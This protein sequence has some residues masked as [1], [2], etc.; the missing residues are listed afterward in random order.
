MSKK[1]YKYQLE[2]TDDI[3]KL[4]IPEGGQ[5]LSVQEQNGGISIWFLVDT[6][7]SDCPREFVI[8]GTGHTVG[9]ESVHH[10]GTV[11]MDG[12]VWHVFEVL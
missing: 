1:I 9:E 11:Q 3:Q 10:L 12:F 6:H 7:A 8:H 4:S 5:F 2:V